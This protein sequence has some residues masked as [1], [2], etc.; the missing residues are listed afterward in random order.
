M[1]LIFAVQPPK[2]LPALLLDCLRYFLH[3]GQQLQE[4]RRQQQRQAAIILEQQQKQQHASAAASPGSSSSA[5]ANQDAQAENPTEDKLK[6]SGSN[7]TSEQLPDLL[8]EVAQTLADVEETGAAPHSADS[9]GDQLSK[10]AADESVGTSKPQPMDD[11]LSASTSTAEEW[12]GKS[13]S[14]QGKGMILRRCMN[15]VLQVRI[16]S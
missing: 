1:Q 12:G 7:G 16:L 13:Q 8:K 6:V 14:G 15:E 3:I 5:S 2:Q 4:S 9:D 11:T 10:P